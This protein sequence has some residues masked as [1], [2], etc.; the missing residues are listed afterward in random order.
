MCWLSDKDVE[1]LIQRRKT[2]YPQWNSCLDIHLYPG[3]VIQVLIMQNKDNQL[4]EVTFT[5]HSLAEYC[6]DSPSSVDV[7]VSCLNYFVF[8]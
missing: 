8:L 3:R 2:V 1:M 5:I 6:K 7:W 4:A